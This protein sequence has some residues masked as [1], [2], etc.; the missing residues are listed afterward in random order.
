[1]FSSFEN[2]L[3]ISR[4]RRFFTSLLLLSFASLFVVFPLHAS[5][6]VASENENISV[7]EDLLA[8]RNND[9]KPDQLGEKVTVRGRATA[10]T[11]ILNDQYLLLYIHDSTAGIMVFSDTLD[12][13]VQKGD[14]LQ[15]TGTLKLHTS[16]PEIVGE[17]L[18]ILP[19]KKRIPKAKPLRKAFENPKQ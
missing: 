15:V 5:Q 13:A 4:I 8:D 3:R 9:G 14:S 7:I 19:A 18:E 17:D 2:R 6:A 12:I 11:N 1:M 16:K 10:S